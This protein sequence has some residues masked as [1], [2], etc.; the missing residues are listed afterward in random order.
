MCCLGFGGVVWVG[1]GGG[2][3]L[4]FYIIHRKSATRE[5][6]VDSSSRS[7]FRLGGL[8]SSGCYQ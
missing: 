5:G 7:N 4:Q 8:G 1:G 2:D 6:F 3:T